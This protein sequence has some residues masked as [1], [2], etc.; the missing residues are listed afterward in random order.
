MDSDLPE[1]KKDYW[2]VYICDDSDPFEIFERKF[3]RP[4]KMASWRE[5]ANPPCDIPKGIRY[6]ELMLKPAKNYL[7]LR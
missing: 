2:W 6:I 1:L 4:A 7:W 5:K 3:G